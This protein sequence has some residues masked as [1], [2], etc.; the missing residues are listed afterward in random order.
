MKNVNAKKFLSCG[1]LAERWSISVSAIYMFRAGTEKLTRHR[2][3]KS[4]RFELAEIEQIEK[5]KLNNNRRKN[6]K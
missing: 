2:F 1:E 6:E 4:I 3:G 5:Q